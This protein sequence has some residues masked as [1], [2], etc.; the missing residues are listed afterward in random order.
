MKGGLNVYKKKKE[1]ICWDCQNYFCSWIANQT[2]VEGWTAKK[3]KIKAAGTKGSKGQ[4][5]TIDSYLVLKCP[6]F[7][8]ERAT[9]KKKWKIYKSPK[10]FIIVR[11]E[12]FDEALKKARRIDK[13]YC[14]G[15]VVED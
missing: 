13:N 6:E 15:Y 10:T 9:K 7:T 1:T 14:G 3:K 12:S 5:A 8:K 11:A 2:P 4:K